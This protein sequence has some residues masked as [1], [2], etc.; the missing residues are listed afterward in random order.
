VYQQS[1]ETHVTQS[2]E[3]RVQYS[4]KSKQGESRNEASSVECVASDG[5]D[6]KRNGGKIGEGDISGGGENG[7][8]VLWSRQRLTKKDKRPRN[9]YQACESKVC[10]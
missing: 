8:V 2:P 7:A 4:N 6:D 1:P 3:K 9:T 5:D 10:V